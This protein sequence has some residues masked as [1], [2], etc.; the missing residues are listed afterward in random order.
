VTTEQ[1]TFTP[2]ITAAIADADR[3]VKPW[4]R[5]SDTWRL[6]AAGLPELDDMAIAM[7]RLAG[8]HE[9]VHLEVSYSAYE[10]TVRRRRGREEF[11]AWSFSEAVLLM[12]A[13]DL[14]RTCAMC[15]EYD[16]HAAS[17]PALAEALIH[18]TTGGMPPAIACG[19]EPGE[20]DTA[21]GAAAQITCPDCA[22]WLRLARGHLRREYLARE[23]DASETGEPVDE[24][25]QP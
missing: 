7:E 9:T 14:R 8:T 4:L 13:D 23:R 22:K 25:G 16:G 1:P 2:E 10:W 17:C 11:F 20:N 18:Y 6:D 19:S 24:E 15:R 5:S 12:L 21:T 3:L